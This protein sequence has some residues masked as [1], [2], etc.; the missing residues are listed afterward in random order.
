VACVVAISAF[1]L[2]ASI[3]LAPHIGPIDTTTGLGL[4]AIRPAFG[5]GSLI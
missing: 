2:G 4:A 1:R 5:I 3:S